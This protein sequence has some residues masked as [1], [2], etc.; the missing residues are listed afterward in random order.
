MAREIDRS[1]VRR[2][3]A[4]D[5]R[6]RFRREC[7]AIAVTALLLAVGALALLVWANW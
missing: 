4:R 7:A 6:E 1:D 5:K 2:A 3:L